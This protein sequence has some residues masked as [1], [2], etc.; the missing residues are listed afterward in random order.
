MKNLLPE[1]TEIPRSYLSIPH[2]NL[3]APVAVP[4]KAGMRFFKAGTAIYKIDLDKISYIQAYGNFYKLY[5][6]D[7]MLVISE[8]LKE[9]ET[10]L[11]ASDFVRIHRS[12]IVPIRKIEKVADHMVYINN[13]KLP[14]G[15]LYRSSFYK[16]I[17][18][19]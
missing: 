9:I 8:P 3:N 19:F 11:D 1:K 13:V 14:V 10:V 18:Q 17:L 16:K 6:N 5:M 12:C 4:A 2:L 15:K 7:E